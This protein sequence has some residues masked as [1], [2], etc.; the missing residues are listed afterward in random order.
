M[1]KLGLFCL[2]KKM[3]RVCKYLIGG[4]KDDEVIFFSAIHCDRTRD[5]L[6]NS[7]FHVNKEEKLL[8]R[9]SGQALVQVVQT[10]C[11]VSIFEGTRN[12][13]RY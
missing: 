8:H 2:E 7:K 4:S 5:K 13:R 11:R 9:E 6:K 3:F 12:L 1:R 10:G